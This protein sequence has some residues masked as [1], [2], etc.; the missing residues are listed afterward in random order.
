MVSACLI[1]INILSILVTRASFDPPIFVR[2]WPESRIGRLSNGN[3]DI[4]ENGKEAIGLHWQNN[5]FARTSRVFVFFLAV[6]ARLWL[7]TSKFHV[8][9]TGVNTRQWVSFCFS[10]PRYSPLEFNSWK[11]ANIWHI[12]GVGIRAMKFETARIHFLGDVF[13]AVACLSSL[14]SPLFMSITWRIVF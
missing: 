2:V 1:P 6:T 11:I 8:L 4:N 14:M 5:N 10:E 3:G 7:E 9:W 13:A 12:K